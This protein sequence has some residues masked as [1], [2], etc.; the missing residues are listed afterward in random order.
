MI[1]KVKEPQPEEVG[2][3]RPGQVLFTYLHLAPNPE[4]ARGALRVGRDLHRLRD[5]RGRRR[6]ACRCSRR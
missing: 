1:L 6:Q 5:R 3:L 4:L 2:L